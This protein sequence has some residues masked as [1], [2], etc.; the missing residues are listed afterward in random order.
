MTALYVSECRQLTVEATLAED[1][2]FEWTKSYTT[3]RF[4]VD[5]VC[6]TTSVT[7][8]ESGV[9]DDEDGLRVEFSGDRLTRAGRPSKQTRD[10]WTFDATLEA[11]PAEPRAAIEQAIA[12][13][14]KAVES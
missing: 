9:G 6:V 13:W 1:E 3:T 10:W 8:D 4:L 7:V 2:R 11:V 5:L 14:R 12:D